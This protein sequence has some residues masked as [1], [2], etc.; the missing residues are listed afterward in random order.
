MIF[1]TVLGVI[2]F[3][4]LIIGFGFLVYGFQIQEFDL[5]EIKENPAIVPF[6]LVAWPVVVME[7]MGYL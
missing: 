2:A 5:D 7:M 1:F 6:V 3:I 4:Y